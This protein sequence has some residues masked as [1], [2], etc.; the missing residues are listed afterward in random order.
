MKIVFVA[1]EVAPYSKT[2]GLADVAGSLPKEFLK[3]GYEVLVITPR[4]RLI[5][6][7]LEYVLLL[8]QDIV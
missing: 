3:M 5:R 1:A 6:Q 2:G 8:H 7:N 4:Y